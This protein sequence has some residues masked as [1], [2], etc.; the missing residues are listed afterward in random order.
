[1]YILGNWLLHIGYMSTITMQYK[2]NL[3]ISKHTL[4]EQEEGHMYFYVIS[5]TIQGDCFTC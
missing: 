1:V 3:F 4:G 2:A 5:V